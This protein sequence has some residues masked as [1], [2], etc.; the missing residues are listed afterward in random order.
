MAHRSDGPAL[1]LGCLG[2]GT[3]QCAVVDVNSKCWKSMFLRLSGRYVPAD[4]AKVK[5]RERRRA[6]ENVNGA[7]MESVGGG[8]VWDS[9]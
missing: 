4:E 6:P 7:N 3:G 8:T 2:M 1:S 9:R 5:H